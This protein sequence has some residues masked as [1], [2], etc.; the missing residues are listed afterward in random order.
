MSRTA[1]RTVD[2]LMT[3]ALLLLMGYHLWGDAVHE[4]VG[5]GM[6]LLFLLHHGLNAGWYTALRRGKWTGGRA[7]QAVIDG[8]LFVDMLAL[9]VSGVA[10]SRHVF[11]F[12]HLGGMGLA[13]SMH[14]AGSY[15]G[16]VLMSMHIGLHW[17]V[18]GKQIVGGA[19]VAV[20]V[21]GQGCHHLAGCE[22]LTV[23]HHS[24][25]AAVDHLKD[26]TCKIRIALGS[27]SSLAVP[28]LHG[29]PA[30]NHVIFSCECVDLPILGNRYMD[31]L[32]EGLAHG[33][34][35]G[36]LPHEIITIPTSDLK[37]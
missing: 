12:L 2:L 4:W 13:R 11:G 15:W 23:H 10:M 37:Q 6:F 1:K 7:A 16:Y 26:N 18:V 17:G 8:L 14:L 21:S 20:L 22:T 3:I 19:G 30:A 25:G 28:F 27:F 36:F 9:T 29:Q 33:S 5:A 35:R 24:V 34:V 32:C 31:F